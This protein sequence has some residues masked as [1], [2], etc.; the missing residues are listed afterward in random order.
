MQAHLLTETEGERQLAQL[1]RDRLPGLKK[2]ADTMFLIAYAAKDPEALA[3]ALKLR[4]EIRAA[5]VATESFAQKEWAAGRSAF[6]SWAQT[7]VTSFETVGAAALDMARTVI[8][9]LRRVAAQTAAGMIWDFI[10]PAKKAGG[11][12]ITKKASGGLLRGAGGPTDDRIPALLSAG[13]YV[14]RA[15]SVARPGALNLLE[16][17]N[18]GELHFSPESQ[19]IL[20]SG[21]L[22]AAL[23]LQPP[24]RNQMMGVGRL[25][26]G[27][28]VQRSAATLTP[29]QRLYGR[30]EIALAEG[31]VVQAIKS[32]AGQKA[33]LEVLKANRRLISGLLG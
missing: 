21:R 20:R 8:D 12:A 25:A 9:A 33:S 32:P 28:L 30:V 16:A 23:E 2:I 5:E 26:E 4:T 10:F 17:L 27:G 15:R 6:V 13:E 7:G 31:L 14:V 22:A 24:T 11:G 29:D 19:E 1:E 18:R 3:A